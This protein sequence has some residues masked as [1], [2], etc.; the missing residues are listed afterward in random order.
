MGEPAFRRGLRPRGPHDQRRAGDGQGWRRRAAGRAVQ[1]SAETKPWFRRRL[2]GTQCQLPPHGD[3]TDLMAGDER[4]SLRPG[5][6]G[7]GELRVPGRRFRRYAS[8]VGAGQLGLRRDGR[9][10]SRGEFRVRRRRQRGGLTWGGRAL[11]R[12]RGAGGQRERVVAVVGLRLRG[13]QAGNEADRASGV[14]LVAQRGEKAGVAPGAEAVA[15]GAGVDRGDGRA[16]HGG[17]WRHRPPV[18]P[19]PVRGRD[20]RGHSAPLV[21]APSWHWVTCLVGSGS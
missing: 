13:G 7:R 14:D 19:R 1:R 2:R 3:G 8:R 4:R 17:R 5:R 6:A 18:V 11:H 20:G 10:S 21:P 15:E 9:Q 12:G 16:Q